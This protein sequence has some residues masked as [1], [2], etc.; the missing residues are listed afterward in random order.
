[1]SDRDWR[2]IR[3]EGLD[4][5]TAMAYDEVA[6][7]TVA[8]GGPATVRVYRWL[9]STLSL[10]YRQPAADVDFDF[11]DRREIRVTRRPTGGGA[12]YHDTYGDISYS[13]I[14][15][16][17]D[18]PGDLMD[19]YEQLCEPLFAFF[20]ELGVDA[21]F[22]EA[23]AP[24][25]YEPACY[26]RALHPAHDIV[27]GPDGRKISGNAQYRQKEA[28]V[29][30]GSITY[31]LQADEHLGCFADPGVTAAEFRDRVTSIAEQTGESDGEAPTGTGEDVNPLG[32][33]ALRRAR[34]VRVLED[35]LADWADA[36]AG[37]WTD[38]ERA[39]AAALAESKYAS[40][41]WIRDRQDPTD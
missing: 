22:V 28:V 23:E 14:A 40:D 20:R 17:D 10:G 29:Q 1:M 11:C 35:A 27:A 41:A 39:R 8:D 25:I 26:L 6:A 16:A 37:D 15:P 9:P 7:E 36:E 21:R 18:V 2:L 24:A 4:G 34:A 3:E 31:E 19:A 12:I 32:G 5:T 13:I 38:D 30:H 33:M